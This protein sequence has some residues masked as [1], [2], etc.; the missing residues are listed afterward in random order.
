MSGVL[1][2]HIHMYP[3][4]VFADPVAWGTAH[5]EAWWTSCVAPAE[6]TSLQGWADVPKLLADMDRAGIEKCV[7]L[8]WYWEHQETCD[9]QAGWFVDWIRQHPD[10][11]IGFAP[12]QPADGQK[13]FDGL[14]RALDAGLSGIGEMLPQAQGFSFEDDNWARVVE[15]AMERDVPINIHVTSPL[16]ASYV[17]THETPLDN[18]LKL[19]TRFPEAKFILAHFGGGIPFYELKPRVRELF[20]NCY[21]DTAAS[22]LIYDQ[23]IFRTVI[24][25]IGPDR[26]LFGTDYPLLCYPRDTLEPDFDRQRADA[27]RM[28]TPAE[29]EKVMGGN[30]RKL[31]GLD[32]RP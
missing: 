7:M 4:E 9:I 17:S 27:V 23:R 25:T 24:D 26:V 12:V 18:Y 29:Q 22:P 10:R 19:V 32:A 1:D 3:P 30:L 15:I 11:L 28:L 20:R 14:Q 6:G 2:S 21:Y 13:A 16:S 31:L 8:G 5:G